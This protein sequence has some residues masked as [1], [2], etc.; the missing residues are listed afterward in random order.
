M[1]EP[2]RPDDTTTAGM[3]AKWK[4]WD[5]AEYEPLACKQFAE[6]PRPRLAMDWRNRAADPRTCTDTALELLCNIRGN[7]YSLEVGAWHIE[8]TGHKAIS[9]S[10]GIPFCEAVTRLAIEVLGVE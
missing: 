5:D 7:M 10:N 4:G 2:K 8:S 3:I 1:T 9:R 6:L